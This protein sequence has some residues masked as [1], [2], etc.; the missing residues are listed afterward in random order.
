[1]P[2]G[3]GDVPDGVLVQILER[4]D[5]DLAAAQAIM[6]VDR[7]FRGVMLDERGAAKLVARTLLTKCSAHRNDDAYSQLNVGRILD[8]VATGREGLKGALRGGIL[9]TAR[10]AGTLA[11]DALL[12]RAPLMMRVAR[13]NMLDPSYVRAARELFAAMRPSIERTIRSE[14]VGETR[15]YGDLSDAE[16]ARVVDLLGRHAF[17]NATRDEIARCDPRAYQN[18]ELEHEVAA[19]IAECRAPLSERRVLATRGPMCFWDTSDVTDLSSAFRSTNFSADLMWPTQNVV[20]MDGT[21][22]DSRFNGRIG[23][24]N[25]ARV[26]SMNYTFADNPV[27]DQPIAAWNVAAVCEMD[28]MFDG[29]VAFKQ[30]LRAWRMINKRFS[31]LT[32]CA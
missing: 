23:H 9:A 19:Y 18:D 24:W 17:T 7:R 22:A 30:P 28:R 2:A 13:Q 25:V 10:N 15:V 31:R 27:F 12:V 14:R 29:A 16:M 3:I 32:H 1:M 6:S 11:H 20:D 26:E 4:V 8:I 21:F 5:Y